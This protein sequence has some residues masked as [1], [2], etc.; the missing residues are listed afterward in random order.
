MLR[1]LWGL[2]FLLVTFPVSAEDA[3]ISLIE[4]GASK[5]WMYRHPAVFDPRSKAKWV[6]TEIQKGKIWLARKGDM[7]NIYT[8][9]A[10]G[11]IESYV[12]SGVKV[13][14]V[15]SNENW[16]TQIVTISPFA[17]EHY[18]FYHPPGREWSVSWFS[19]KKALGSN[20]LMVAKCKMGTLKPVKEQT[21]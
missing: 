20:L 9:D 19:G 2:G 21:Q 16:L 5:G 8:I 10:L 6:E 7:W 3:E 1:S 13:Q 15:L 18:M 14:R 17:V 12:D 4:C 11:E